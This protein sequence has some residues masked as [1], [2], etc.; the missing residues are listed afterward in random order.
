M[1]GFRD[2]AEIDRQI[3]TG[4]R[5]QQWRERKSIFADVAAIESWRGNLSAQ[6]DLVTADGAERLRGALATTNFFDVLGVSPTLGRLFN[7]SDT[8]AVVISDGFWRRQFGGDA[9]IVGRNHLMHS[10]GHARDRPTSSPE[11]CRLRF[12]SHTPTK[13]RRS[14]CFVL[15]HVGATPRRRVVFPD[16]RATQ[17]GS[18]RRTGDRGTRNAYR[19][20]AGGSRCSRRSSG[21]RVGRAH[22]RIHGRPRAAGDSAARGVVRERAADRLYQRRQPHAGSIDNP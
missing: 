3:A 6:P 14:D 5:V 22:P 4:E 19:C 10:A 8:A 11:C 12:A 13:N 20:G 17:L 1:S 9:A 7:A 21:H 2:A 16:R 18:H 15:G